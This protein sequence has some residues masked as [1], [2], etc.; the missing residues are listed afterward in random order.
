MMD[1]NKVKKSVLIS[2]LEDMAAEMLD[3]TSKEFFTA[4]DDVR[5]ERV[6]STVELFVKNQLKLQKV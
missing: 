1:L 5:L 2:A 4:F 6:R 3:N